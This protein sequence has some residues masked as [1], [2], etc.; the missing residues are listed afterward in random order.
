MT[1]TRLLILLTV[2]LLAACAA[3]SWHLGREPYLRGADAYYYA[4]QGE[5]WAKTGTVKIPDASPVHRIIGAL[6]KAGLTGEASVR[7]WEVFSLLLLGFAGL[8][9]VAY[10]PDFRKT[11]FWFCLA[12]SPSVLFTAIEF[13]KFF[14]AVLLVPLWFAALRLPRSP[15][16][17]AIA[18]AAASVALHRAMLPVSLAFTA[19]VLLPETRRFS[20][21]LSAVAAAGLAVAVVLAFWVFHDRLSF[22]NA[23]PGLWT[24]LS[25]D[26]L[27]LVIKA[28]IVL[29]FAT[30]AVF[31]TKRRKEDGASVK[32]RLF[33]VALCLPA[34]FP[35]GTDEV[36]GVGERYAVLTPIFL[37]MTML[38][39]SSRR[40]PLLD[41]GFF[42]TIALVVLAATLPL[43]AGFRLEASHPKTLDPDSAAFETIVRE[44]APLNPPMLI[45]R[46]DF[47]FF[48]KYRLM[49]EAFPYEPE[50]HWDK[51]KI[52][53]LTYAVTPEELQNLLPER[54]GWGSGLVRLS[55]VDGY[56]V[57]REDCWAEMRGKILRENDADL[58][59]RTRETWLNP[60]QKR[61]AFLY[62]KHEDDKDE[63]F[64]ALKP[65]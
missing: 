50:D 2:S 6:Q 29:S 27:P 3:L 5:Y 9:L 65:K 32:D 64:P 33:P 37:W 22:E 46:K 54:C 21:R 10:K 18:L 60:S 20:A 1:K 53:R 45:A 41:R 16:L 42:Q 63:A 28:E 49:R 48:Y 23:R 38:S 26:Q 47:V 39:A 40:D 61:P 59:E 58:Y 55:S 17:A 62:P 52:W 30:L 4:L 11:L 14:S 34:L 19:I 56:A 7:A 31:I 44:I 8:T 35:F 25:R 57:V 24:L 15:R 43:S 13:P 12:L 51:S 36:F